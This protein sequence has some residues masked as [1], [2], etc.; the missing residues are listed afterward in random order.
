[1][2]KWHRWIGLPAAIF[3]LLSGFTGIWL[4]CERFFGEEEAL[5]EKLR[6]TL[7]S[8]SA[9]TPPAEFAAQLA[10]AQAAVAAKAGDQPLDKITWQLKGDSPTLTFYLGGT[11]TLKARKLILNAKT[12]ALL[13]EDDYDDD[14]FILKLH[15]GEIYG[16]GGM[17]LGMVWALALMALTV[18]GLVIYWKM[19]PKDATGLRKVFWL[20]PA[21][22]LALPAA[23]AD[24][25][26]VTDDPLFSPGW[27]I[28][29]G[30]TAE[31][32]ANSRILVAPVLDLN[33]AVV[34][35]LR[36]NL[37][38][39]ERTVTPRGGVTETGFGDTEFKVKWR[40][41]EENTNNW[42]PALGLAPKFFAPT[43]QEQ[44]WE[45]KRVRPRPRAQVLRPHRQRPQGPG[46][47]PLARAAS[48]PVRQEPRPWFLWG[49]AGYQLTLHRTATDNAFGGV[50][51][52]Y[53]FNSHFALGTEINDTLPLKDKANHNLLTSV[54]AIYTFN[55]HW[56]LK[57]SISRTLRHESRGGPNPGGVSYLVW[58]F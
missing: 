18:T 1:M 49:E 19:R 55:E 17:V 32:N 26:F 28:K 51:V 40:F 56:A 14:S 11:K 20:L 53:N 13:K 31:R 16:D 58:N 52:L 21:S 24:S 7:S 22:L 30:G 12:S 50:G 54:G 35:N 41:H 5:R 25:P 29:F 36:L 45:E 34:D 44:Q 4:E 3:F 48:P 23:R 10:A 39:Q 37:T 6:D 8:V 47:R 15:S 57:A 27:E 33:Y 38:L 2:R 42:V 46:R 9:K 43:R